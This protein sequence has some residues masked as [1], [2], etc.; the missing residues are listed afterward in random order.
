MFRV[1]DDLAIELN[2]LVADEGTLSDHLFGNS[3]CALRCSGD[4]ICNLA[5]RS[6]AERAAKAAS[7]HF[8]NHST[9]SQSGGALFA[10]RD[11]LIY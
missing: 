9:A 5:F 11:Y 3:G 10:V 6:S 1:R 2:A 7:F 4:N 8:C